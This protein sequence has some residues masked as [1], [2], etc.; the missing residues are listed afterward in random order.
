MVPVL[1]PIVASSFFVVVGASSMPVP[2]LLVVA[3][4]GDSNEPYKEAN[5]LSK[6]SWRSFN[7]SKEERKKR[8]K[9]EK[10]EDETK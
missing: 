7:T 6:W 10:E 8:R 3:S 2:C 4:V 5:G 9:E 1:F